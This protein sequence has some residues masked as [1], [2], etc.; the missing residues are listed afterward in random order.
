MLAVPFMLFQVGQDLEIET[1]A[2]RFTKPAAFAFSGSVLYVAE[3]DGRIWALRNDTPRLVI[4]GL[5]P[6]VNG[7][8][9]IGDSLFIS[10][11]GR[12]SVFAE[13]K[14]TDLITGLPSFGSC[15][16]NG[17]T[18]GPG[19]M[20]YFGQGEEDCF[21]SSHSLSG[22][23]I[24]FRRDGTGLEVF[25]RGFHD[26]WGLAF[27]GDTL[28]VTDPG[29]YPPDYYQTLDGVYRV[30][31]KGDWLSVHLE[32]GDYPRGLCFWNDTLYIACFGD[33]FLRK[34]ETRPRLIKLLKKKGRYVFRDIPLDL[35]RPIDVKPGPDGALYVL[36][37]EGGRIFRLRRKK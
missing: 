1:L 24:R 35:G 5:K 21:S 32:P 22:A 9:P 26:P 23:I 16:N 37:G 29:C 6:P 19:G 13:G 34:E 8:L 7:I 27:Q 3:Q 33:P 30:D 17:L 36:D 25:S 18:L 31:P 15:S 20:I 4:R 14:L 2:V 28:W 12:V 11:R 10:H